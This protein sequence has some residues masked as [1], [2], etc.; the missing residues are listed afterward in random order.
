MQIINSL[1]NPIFKNLKKLNSQAKERKKQQK[2]LLDGIRLIES[3]LQNVGLPELLIVSVGAQA[4]D[5]V[6][7]LLHRCADVR[8]VRLSE[9]L[10]NQISPSDTPAGI[11]AMIQIPP[12]VASS[13]DCCIL[14]EDIQDPGNLGSILRSAAAAGINT[15]YISRD[16]ADAWS[17]RVLR[18]GMGAHFVMRIFE[19]S[20]LSNIAAQFPGMIVATSPSAKQSVYECD[21]SGSVAFII[22]NEGAGISEQLMSLATLCI[23]IPLQSS[24][25]SL[26][27]AAAAAVCFFERLRQIRYRSIA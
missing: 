6:A 22:G 24:V 1:D 7:A 2:T 10:F 26:N 17:P 11:M 23:N 8:L 19:R 14:L 21:L 25:E 15:A 4:R 5:D 18:G 27:V 9:Q 13:S 3:Y 20:V 12:E 16:S